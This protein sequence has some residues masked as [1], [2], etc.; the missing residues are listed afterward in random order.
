MSEWKNMFT[1]CKNTF[2]KFNI[3]RG[4]H[5]NIH[6]FLVRW[7]DVS[8]KQ[9]QN[10]KKSQTQKKRD[11]WNAG[12]CR[13]FA[14]GQLDEGDRRSRATA[15]RICVDLNP[16]R[17]SDRFSPN[18]FFFFY[19]TDHSSVA[20][21]SPSPPP[22]SLHHMPVLPAMCKEALRVAELSVERGIFT[23]TSEIS[24]VAL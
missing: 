11:L 9:K 10:R 15:E 5:S 2:P 4:S 19:L 21:P 23:P 14:G 3:T 13:H 22:P 6:S 7:L 12:V 1:C 20:M 18:F 16:E 8:A 24:A 17:N